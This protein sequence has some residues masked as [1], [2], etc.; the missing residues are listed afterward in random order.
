MT[1]GSQIWEPP[2]S[3]LLRFAEKHLDHSVVDMIVL[4]IIADLQ[5][6]YSKLPR[7]DMA[8]SL[9]L[10]RGY[11]SFW[12]AIGLHTIIS[13]DG[14]MRIA[15][16]VGADAFAFALFSLAAFL[17]F[18]H[19]YIFNPNLNHSMI[20][21]SA[22]L[23]V[24]LAALAITLAVRARMTAY[25]IAGFVAFTAS[26]LVVQGYY[27][28]QLA[29]L[30]GKAG[31]RISVV[32]DNTAIFLQGRPLF[33]RGIPPHYSVMGAALMGVALGAALAL[34]GSKFT[35]RS[36]MGQGAPSADNP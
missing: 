7:T 27:G 8:R 26:E 16:L 21:W 14:K 12:K 3:R 9:V 33:V 19:R 10:L 5:H 23:L 2:G 20:S 32:R 24:C 1:H 13:G 31:V 28:F 22:Q 6:E 30:Q 36:R 15:K 11:W 34:W 29:L 4:P 18:R 35:Y 17:Y 25:C